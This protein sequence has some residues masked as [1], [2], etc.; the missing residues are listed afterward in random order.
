MTTLPMLYIRWPTEYNCC[1]DAYAI[2]Q[3]S[4]VCFK[5]KYVMNVKHVYVIMWSLHTFVIN[6]LI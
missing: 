2:C 3:K 1:Y 5:I 4:R 6:T